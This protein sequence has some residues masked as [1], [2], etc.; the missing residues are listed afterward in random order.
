MVEM[1]KRKAQVQVQA[2]L[3]E[4]SIIGTGPE[5]WIPDQRN[6]CLALGRFIWKSPLGKFQNKLAN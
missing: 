4:A 2:G 3:M 1:L 6:I 5:P